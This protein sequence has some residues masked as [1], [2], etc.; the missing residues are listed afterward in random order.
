MFKTTLLAG[1]LA[2]TTLLPAYA[3]DASQAE[4][5]VETQA[6]GVITVLQDMRA[7]EREMAEVKADFRDRINELADVDRITNF[8]LGRYRR[9]AEPA[10]LEEFQTV[11]RE[12]AI[13]VYE[14]ELT[15]YSGQTLDVTGSVTRDENDWVV[16]S[17]VSGGPD[18]D[19]YEVNWRVQERDGTLKVLDAQVAGVWL[20]QTQREQITSV[21]GNAGGNIQAAIDTLCGRIQDQDAD[22]YARVCEG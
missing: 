8:V 15:N 14:S 12:F 22:D 3:A 7:G 21:I 9:G 13:N 20:A 11:F 18:G 17:Q 5:F 16:R 6:Q 19:V 10:T 1:L 4:D 2:C